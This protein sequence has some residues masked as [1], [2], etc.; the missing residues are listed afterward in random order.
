MLPSDAMTVC[1]ERGR[2]LLVGSKVR[3][4]ALEPEDI[5]LMYVWEND[6]CMWEV[7][8]T[9]VPFSRETMREFIENQQYD[10]YRTR[11]VRFVIC[12]LGDDIPVGMIDLFDFDPVN[13]RAGIGVVICDEVERRKGYAGEALELVCE[14]AAAILG[15]HQVWCNVGADNFSSIKLFSGRKFVKVGALLE[16]FRRG[17]EWMDEIVFQRILL[18]PTDPG[19][20]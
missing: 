3:L 15:L 2:T 5:D 9:L 18:P 12:R 6:P 1:G 7:S 16:W 13:L 14:Y 19:A 20:K 4:R 11:Q 10:I 17:E 8:G